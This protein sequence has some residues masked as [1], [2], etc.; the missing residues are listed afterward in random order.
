M[1]CA[2]FNL[3]AVGFSIYIDRFADF[4]QVFGSLSAVFVFLLAVYVAVEILLLGA[5]L[6]AAW[7]GTA[8]A[9]TAPGGGLSSQLRRAPSP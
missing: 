3:V 7:P 4:N 8:H 6:T 9:A 1:A 5:S 2:G